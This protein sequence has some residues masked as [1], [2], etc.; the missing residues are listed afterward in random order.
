MSVNDNFHQNTSHDNT[1]N[2]KLWQQMAASIYTQLMI[3]PYDGLVNQKD[4]NLSD[5]DTWDS[6]FQD[7]EH[8]SDTWLELHVFLVICVS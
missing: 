2:L 3:S 1:M 7:S 4:D 8:F 5:D 6:F